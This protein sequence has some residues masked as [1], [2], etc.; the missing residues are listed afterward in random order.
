MWR[1]MLNCKA[2]VAVPCLAMAVL[3]S[4]CTPV[5]A[6]AQNAHD[7]PAPP[8]TSRSALEE[9]QKGVES[10]QRAE[11]LTVEAPAPSEHEREST[12]NPV[13]LAGIAQTKSAEAIYYEV[14]GRELADLRMDVARIEGKLSVYMEDYV[15]ALRNEN[16]ELQRE[17][18]RLSMTRQDNLSSGGMY[19]PIPGRRYMEANPGSGL[20]GANSEQADAGVVAEDEGIMAIA[21]NDGLNYMLVKEWG[22]TATVAARSGDGAPSLKGMIGAVPPNTSEDDLVKL[23]QQ[24][25]VEFNDFDNINITMFDN[26][27]IASVYAKTNKMASDPILNIVKY[28]SEGRDDILVR[29]DGMLVK[30]AADGTALPAPV[31]KAETSVSTQPAAETVAAENSSPAD[32]EEDEEVQRR[33]K[34][35]LDRIQGV[36]LTRPPDFPS[37]ADGNGP[38]ANEPALDALKDADKPQEAEAPDAQKEDEKTNTR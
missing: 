36:P 31:A 2:A 30:I 32:S 37:Q 8:M 1:L 19:K 6:P 13:T 38:A 5:E 4:G 23:G 15:A 35:I 29:R 10:L 18:Q 14:L 33:A 7:I 34:A 25:R 12:A 21:S 22:R 28:P 24:L 9:L 16:L 26:A 3:L 17:I 20:D 27:E 11:S